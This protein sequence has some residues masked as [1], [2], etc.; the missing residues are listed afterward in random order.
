MIRFIQ[1]TFMFAL[2]DIFLKRICT[3]K[4]ASLGQ[5]NKR[6]IIMMDDDHDHT[7]VNDLK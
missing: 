2:I 5:F 1:D 4:L 7:S 6:Q 3:L